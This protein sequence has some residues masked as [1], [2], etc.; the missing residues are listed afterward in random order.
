MIYVGIDIAKQKHFAAAMTSDGEVLIPP[1]GFT[2]NSEG[3]TLLL[4]KLKSFDKENLIVGLESTAHY[5]ENLICYLYDLCYRIA[6]SQSYNT[7]LSLAF[8]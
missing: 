2:N 1:F 5:G 4:S 8:T 3:F 7:S 6:I